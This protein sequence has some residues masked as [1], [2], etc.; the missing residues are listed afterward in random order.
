MDGGS[1]NA[2]LTARRSVIIEGRHSGRSLFPAAKEA[3]MTSIQF[4]RVEAASGSASV[5]V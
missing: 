2:V 3:K 5:S 1:P 4:I